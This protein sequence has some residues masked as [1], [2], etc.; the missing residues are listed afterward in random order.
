MNRQ[1][2]GARYVPIFMGEWKEDTTYESLSIVI[3]EQGT[4]TSK[5]YVPAGTSILN[6]EYWVAIGSYNGFIR[7]LDERITTLEQPKRMYLFVG[8]SYGVQANSWV[9]VLA[10]RLN[11]NSDEYE[12]LCVSGTGFDNA[13]NGF[14]TQIENYKGDKNKVTCIIVCG[15]ANDAINR[16]Q[17][18]FNSLTNGI[19]NFGNYAKENYPNAKVWCGFIGD[20]LPTSS[21]FNDH[22]YLNLEWAKYCYSNMSGNANML[23]LSGVENALHANIYGFSDDGLHPNESGSTAI[24]NAIY[25]SLENSYHIDYPVISTGL[26]G[27]NGYTFTNQIGEYGING[28]VCHIDMFLPTIK[29]S[30]ET[31]LNPSSDVIIGKNPYLLF[32][33]RVFV[34]VTL[35][36]NSSVGGELY[37]HCAANLIFDKDNIIIQTKELNNEKNGYKTYTVNENSTISVVERIDLTVPTAMIN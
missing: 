36:F 12:N 14:L 25:N 6:T 18:N 24:G 23:Y 30:T 7:N 29:V 22:K 9:N 35:Q 31:T 8:D 5:K 10:K 3:H 4:Y 33:K 27:T 13:G 15:G 21:F 20:V 37:E 17:E 16:T 19:I 28:D 32:K 2:I 1:Y 11:L 34:P 26:I